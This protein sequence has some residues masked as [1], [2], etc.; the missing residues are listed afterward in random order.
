M[1]VPFH[2]AGPHLP[3]IF[4]AT[5]RSKM[6]RI[7]EVLTYLRDKNDYVSGD[8]M[9][10]TIGISRTAVWKYINHLER[11][12]YRIEK[13]KGK[14]YRLAEA[15]DKLYPWEVERHVT[16]TVLGKKII[17]KD[18]LDS[19]NAL[20]FRLAL[21]GEPEGTCVIA[22]T[23]KSGKGRLGRKWFSPAGK[24][25]YMSVLL[26]PRI[27]P[28]A[29]YPITFLSSLA[30]Y[31]TIETLVRVQ[32]TLKWPNDVLI[33]GKKVCGTLLELSTEAD[34]VRFV[35][36]GIGLNI[37]MKEDETE[38]EIRQK[39]TSFFMEARKSFERTAVCG[40][41]LDNLERYYRIFREKGTDEI[42]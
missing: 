34:M 20:A 9:S 7:R 30:V 26:R 18:N 29:V 19:T 13:L 35:I 37:N 11:L 15:P 36:V 1:S 8:Y 39:A 23:Q 4:R 33:A 41:L 14:G 38:E 21:S 6:D 32:P 10:G 40:I 17:Y 5:T 27:P 31:D 28:S 24:N 2:K 22:E 3:C 12:G 25:L 42:C 16:A